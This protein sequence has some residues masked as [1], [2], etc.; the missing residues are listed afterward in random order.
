MDWNIRLERAPRIEIR[1]APDG[2]VV[3][4]AERDRL[5]YLNRTAALLFE[6]CDGTLPAAE[7]PALLAAV[8]NLDAPPTGEVEACLAKLLHEGL[9]VAAPAD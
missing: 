9:L 5:H 3:Y 8:F 1:E 7:I 2:F 6:S 4:D